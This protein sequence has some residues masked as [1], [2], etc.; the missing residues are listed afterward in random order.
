M[1]KF[2]KAGKELE[3]SISV[4]WLLETVKPVNAAKTTSVGN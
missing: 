4:I 2:V 1:V 3:K